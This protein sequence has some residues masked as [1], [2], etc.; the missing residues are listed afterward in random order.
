VTWCGEEEE[1]SLLQR[2]TSV[3]E[4]LREF[5]NFFNSFLRLLSSSSFFFLPIFFLPFPYH[6]LVSIPSDR[7]R[8]RH[9]QTKQFGLEQMFSK[10]EE[11]PGGGGD[12]LGEV[13]FLYEKLF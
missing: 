4:E 8:E 1:A 12:F 10:C 6:L 11:R 9:I 3:K 13:V 5:P 7:A 2:H